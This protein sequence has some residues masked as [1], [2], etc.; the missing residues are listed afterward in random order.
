[1]F[2]WELVRRRPFLTLEPLSRGLARI[3]NTTHHNIQKQVSDKGLFRHCAWA[4]LICSRVVDLSLHW[5][6]GIPP[7]LA[8]KPLQ[9]DG[10]RP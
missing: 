3:Y 2:L 9:N 7:N 1:M 6:F 4:A 5:Q 10:G 8:P